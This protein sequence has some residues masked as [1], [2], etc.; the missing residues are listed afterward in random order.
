MKKDQFLIDK[1]RYE[2][3]DCYIHPTSASYNDISLNFEEKHYQQLT[4]AGIDEDLAKHIAHLF[5]RDPLQVKLLILPFLIHPFLLFEALMTFLS[6][7]IPS[8]PQ[9]FRFI[10]NAS[11]KT[12]TN[13]LNT[14][15]LYNPPIGTTC[16]SSPLLLMSQK[17]VGESRFAPWKSS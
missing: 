1:S 8:Y 12:T 5:I 2:T 6:P 9:F 17:S 4:S 10:T 16:A 15:K 13:P 14:S 3:T 11:N 7:H